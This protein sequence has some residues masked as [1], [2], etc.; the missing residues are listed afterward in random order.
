[1]DQCQVNSIVSLRLCRQPCGLSQAA[2]NG[3][4]AGRDSYRSRGQLGSN[5]LIW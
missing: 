5:H 3:S 2:P 4:T 1:M